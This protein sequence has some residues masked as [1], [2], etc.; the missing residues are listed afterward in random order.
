MG[1]S[2]PAR[3][4]KIT[5]MVDNPIKTQWTP[6]P[7][8]LL[9]SGEICP[10]DKVVLFL[11]IN[12]ALFHKKPFYCLSSW[13]AEQAGIG[14]RTV[15]ESIKH[16]KKLGF[17]SVKRLPI[18]TNVYSVC[19]DAINEYKPKTKTVSK[20]AR[21]PTSKPTAKSSTVEDWLNVYGKKEFNQWLDKMISA[22][23]NQ[24]LMEHY[25]DE[26]ISTVQA[27]CPDADA[28][29]MKS[30]WL[31]PAYKEYKQSILLN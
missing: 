17:I 16:L 22:Q 1:H 24:P 9:L 20:K 4:L 2:R 26:I 15:S 21:K 11:M 3:A 30:Q 28:E 5:T 6:V 31:R 29:T 19:W 8:S 23:Q 14:E 13:F 25:L 12:R 18:G 7:V 10:T 27:K